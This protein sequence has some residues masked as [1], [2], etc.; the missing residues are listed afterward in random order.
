MLDADL[1]QDAYKNLAEM[2]ANDLIALGGKKTCEPLKPGLKVYIEYSNETWN[3]GFSQAEYCRQEGAALGLPGDDY[4]AGREFHAWAALKMYRAMEDVF[5]SG[6]PR[7]VK[8]DAYQAVVPSQ[9]TDHLKI[10]DNPGYN[11]DGLYPDAFSPAPYFGNDVD[12]SDQNMKDELVSAILDRTGAVRQARK[13]LDKATRD[14]NPSFKLIAYEGGQHLLTHADAGNRKQVMYELY[15]QYLDSMSNYLDGMAHYLHSGTFGSGGAWGAKEYIGQPVAD[16]PKFKAIFEWV[17]GTA[18]R[19]DTQKPDKPGDLS[20]DNIAE[21]SFRVLWTPSSDN[22]TVAFYTVL[23]DGTVYTQ[24][25]NNIVTLND[26]EPGRTYSV[27]IV[28]VDASGNSSE[29]SAPLVVTT[30]GTASFTVTF[31]VKEGSLPLQGADVTFN[32]QTL[33]TDAAGEAVFSNQP[34]G[35]D[36][37]YEVGMDL[38]QTVQGTVSLIHS[39]PVLDIT[40]TKSTEGISPHSDGIQIYPNPSGDFINIQSDRIVKNVR[41]SDLTGRTVL[42]VSPGT[43]YVRLSLN[44]LENGIYFLHLGMMN[45]DKVIQKVVVKK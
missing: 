45:G 25:P 32:T 23:V 13:I 1:D 7:L 27:T 37:P 44:S 31:K 21:T 24:T 18:T 9:I 14:G 36:Q 40:L 15:V 2:T 5:G 35:E 42:H 39:D 43:T 10:Y 22:D 17:N 19:P 11:P 29:E 6:S 41:V 20:S 8:I 28:A 26:L 4:T 3:F 12:G 16:A 30:T 34:A 33:L 38:Y